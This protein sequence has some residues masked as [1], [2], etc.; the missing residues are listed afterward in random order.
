MRF[1]LVNVFKAEVKLLLP[2][3]FSVEMVLFVDMSLNAILHIDINGKYG[4]ECLRQSIV[5]LYGMV[6][7]FVFMLQFSFLFYHTTQ[8]YVCQ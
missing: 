3:T 1:L 5:Y 7:S 2:G 8:F 6:L 4:R